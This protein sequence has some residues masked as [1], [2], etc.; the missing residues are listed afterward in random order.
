MTLTCNVGE[1]D[2]LIRIVLAIGLLG[3][4]VTGLVSGALA[5]L[6]LVFGGVFMLTSGLSYCPVYALLGVDTCRPRRAG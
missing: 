4:P 3:L 6:L 1:A 2:R 5:V